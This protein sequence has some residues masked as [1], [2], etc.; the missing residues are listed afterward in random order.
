M[1]RLRPLAQGVAQRHEATRRQR[2]RPPR[3]RL[4]RLP[5][6]ARGRRPPRRP[7]RARPDRR[8]RRAPGVAAASGGARPA[9][10]IGI[11]TGLA[12]VSASPNMPEPVV[13][14]TTL[15]VALRLQAAAAPGTVVI[16]PATRSLVRRGFTTEALAPLPPSAA[17]SRPFVPVSRPRGERQPATSRLRPG[18]AGRPGPRARS[19]HQPLGAG[20]RRHRPGGAAQRRA[21]HRQVAPAAGAARARH[22]GL[23]RRRGALAV[24]ARLAL[25]AEHAAASGGRRCCAGCSPRSPARRRPS[26]SRRCCGPSRSP[27]RCRCS[28]RCSICPR[29]RRRSAARVDA[30]GTAARGDARGAGRAAAGD[31]RARAG[32]P[33]GRGS[34][35]ARRDDADLARA[36]DRPGDDGA[37]A[38][39]DDDPAQHPRHPVGIA[40][41]RHADRARRAQQ[42]GNRAAD[43]A[44]LG[45]PRARRRASSSTSSPRPTACRSSSRS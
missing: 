21:R 8:G 15:D 9:L 3:A 10:R 39:G 25:H 42:P 11:H 26:S 23:G 16:S 22:R 31:V 32:D 20:A 36:P 19:A 28:P 13:L 45:R 12:V 35:L 1:M 34:A 40:G 14:G 2:R 7:R 5:A 41:P 37:A 29:R 38:A 33:A 27:R 24:D 6:G 4:L 17:A 44:A 30:A 43:P 18:A